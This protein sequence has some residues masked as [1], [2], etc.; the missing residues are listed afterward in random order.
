MH[1]IYVLILCTSIMGSGAHG[2]ICSMQ[3]FSSLE[4]CE[5]AGKSVKDILG[6]RSY[7]YKCVQK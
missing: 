6:W 4:G 7:G 3:E 5:E 1:I 2:P